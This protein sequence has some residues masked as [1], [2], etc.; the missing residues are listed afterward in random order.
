MR[1]RTPDK[2]ATAQGRF[3]RRLPKRISEDGQAIIAD[4]R[5]L[6]PVKSIRKGTEKS[7]HTR[8]SASI[9]HRGLVGRWLFESDSRVQEA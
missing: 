2:A 4:I 1:A 5:R 6:S 8:E 9:P 3:F 7:R